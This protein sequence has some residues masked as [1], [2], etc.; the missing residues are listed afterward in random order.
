MAAMTAVQNL[1]NHLLRLRGIPEGKAGYRYKIVVDDLIVATRFIIP[2]ASVKQIF[3]A[4]AN[5]QDNEK[6][7]T[8]IK[9][10]DFKALEGIYR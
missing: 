8:E 9:S 3:T 1:V 6:L 2:C 7:K 5:F 4:M 10:M